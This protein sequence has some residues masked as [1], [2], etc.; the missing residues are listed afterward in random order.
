M[1]ETTMMRASKA[2]HEIVT[3]HAAEENRTLVAELDRIVAA[4]VA[5]LYGPK[6]RRKAS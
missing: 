3:R 1:A 5:A 4:G 2:T 6:G